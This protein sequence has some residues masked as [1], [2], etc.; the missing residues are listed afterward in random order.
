MK[1]KDIVCDVE[2][3]KK[4]KESGLRVSSLLFYNVITDEVVLND[5]CTNYIN[6]RNYAYTVAELG[7]MLPSYI[8]VGSSKQICEL[9]MN[10]TDKPWKRGYIF[11]Y[12]IAE[13]GRAPDPKEANARARLLIWLIESKFVN[14]ED[15]NNE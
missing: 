12:V 3:S 1:L 15:L 2:Y 4:L 7:A 5:D 8:I 13:S 14:V 6:V 10:I 11:G 9:S